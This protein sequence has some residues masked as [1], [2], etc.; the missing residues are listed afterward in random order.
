LRAT[1]R[2]VR[3]G[4]TLLALA[5]VWGIGLSV[6]ASAADR[7][8]GGG[9]AVSSDSK[10]ERLER[11]E[12]GLSAIRGQAYRHPVVLESMGDAELGEFL[13]RKLAEDYPEGALT[14][15]KKAY[16]HF[17]LLR[18]EDDLRALF[19]DMLTE[20]AAGFY[21][22][23]E[24]R[25]FLVA[26]RPFPGA[27]LVHELAHALQDQTFQVGPIIDAARS[28]DDRLRAVQ[29]MI[30]GEAMALT[31]EYTSRYPETASRLDDGVSADEER[32][33]AQESLDSLRRFPRILQAE[34]LFPYTQGMAWA[35]SVVRRGGESRMDQLFRRP[36]DSTEQILHPEKL[37][38]PR[39]EVSRIDPDLLP[40]L[41][42]DGY[43][44]VRTNTMGE[45][46]IRQLLGGGGD[47]A[48]IDAA[49]GWD[50]DTYSVYEDP[51]GATAMVWVSVW[52]SSDDAA[53]FRAAA[54]AWLDAR[55]A[56]GAGYRIETGG[57][58]DVV[59]TV[60]EGFPGALETRLAAR[61]AAGLTAG[62]TRR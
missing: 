15:E 8:P 42:G 6:P 45:F 57:P 32:R 36:P 60:I 58:D 11:I 28:D 56:D 33:Q 53:Q 22:P 37:G 18:P 61:V 54:R 21:D 34:L 26:G 52:D 41:S 10:A 25:L 24:K 12:E 38:P 55:H 5:L 43:R 47:Q 16:V 50:G 14:D 40:A 23:D 35:Q 59:V 44:I 62:V 4:L 20:Q 31:A 51:T 1:G 7:P 29:A 13:S 49:A 30:E 19:L 17:R 27:A 39:D 48:A 9:A 2:P 46:G 3:A